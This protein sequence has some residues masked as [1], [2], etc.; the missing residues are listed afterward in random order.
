MHRIFLPLCGLS[1]ILLGAAFFLGWQIDDPKVA[2]VAVQRGVQYHF[3]TALGAIVFATLVHALVLTYFMGTGRW[4]EETSNAYRLDAKFYNESKSLKY[5]VVPA[6]VGAFLLLLVTGAFGAAADPGSPAQFRGW[7]GLSPATIHQFFAIITLT[8]NA[9][10]NY[11]E[12]AG[13]FRSSEIIDEAM[14]AVRAIR[15]SKGLA[16]E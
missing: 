7:F 4:L 13:L 3:L 15:L 10:V 12:F 2:E 9:W 5:R 11:L 14:Q 8:V 1:W 6:L 16:V